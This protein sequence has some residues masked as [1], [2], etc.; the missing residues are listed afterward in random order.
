MQL[1][2][3]AGAKLEL[4]R[5]HQV[6]SEQYTANHPLLCIEVIQVI[7]EVTQRGRLIQCM[8]HQ[9]LLKGCLFSQLALHSPALK[10]FMLLCLRQ[11]VKGASSS[12]Y[13]HCIEMNHVNVNKNMVKPCHFDIMY[14]QSL[15]P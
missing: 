7:N 8:L 3:Y 2:L 1:R 4:V 5:K 14:G 13:I 9:G 15:H 6:R 11:T 10:P 12:F